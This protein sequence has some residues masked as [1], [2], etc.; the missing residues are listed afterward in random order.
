MS[1]FL[2]RS[3]V[4]F[5][6]AALLIAAAA[7]ADTI[8]FTDVYG[9]VTGTTTYGGDFP[10]APTTGTCQIDQTG[11]FSSTATSSWV[12]TQIASPIYI[13]DSAGNVSAE[14]I[15]TFVGEATT[16][17]GSGEVIVITYYMTGGLDLS[18]PF[19]CGSVGGCQFT[20]DGTLQLLGTTTYNPTTAFGQVYTAPPTPVYF[21]YVAPEPGSIGLFAAGLV[22]LAGFGWRRRPGR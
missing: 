20:E 9:T 18:S 11:L 16:P 1:V 4:V 14:L 12:N 2:N 22:T 5:A 17:P 7:K 19:T 13:G 6:T 21:Q 10:C 15:S 3:K 8:T